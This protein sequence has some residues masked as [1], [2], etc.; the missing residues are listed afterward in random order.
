[1]TS[2]LTTVTATST[3]SRET[4][5]TAV[6]HVEERLKWRW[7]GIGGTLKRLRPTCWSVEVFLVLKQCPETRNLFRD[8]N[9]SYGGPETAETMS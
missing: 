6:T 1:M 8:V 5:E 3:L 2:G 7:V 4:P 9:Y